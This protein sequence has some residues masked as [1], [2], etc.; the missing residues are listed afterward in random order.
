MFT[1]RDEATDRANTEEPCLCCLCRANGVK[2]YRALGDAGHGNLFCDPCGS[3]PPASD[4]LLVG[5]VR[6][7]QGDL[8][9]VLYADQETGDAWHALPRSLAGEN[10]Q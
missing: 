4:H 7:S 8:V 6:G 10:T 9:S 3:L 1:A 2:L 5:V